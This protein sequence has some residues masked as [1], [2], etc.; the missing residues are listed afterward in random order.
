[1]AAA[2]ARLGV[3]EPVD[4]PHDEAHLAVFED[5]FRVLYGELEMHRRN[6]VIHLAALDLACYDRE[7]ASEERRMEARTRHVERWPEAIENAV[8]SLDMVAPPV[9]GRLLGSVK[10]LAQGLPADGGRAADAARAAHTRLVA[11]LGE[12]AERD[13]GI[14]SAVLGGGPFARLMGSADGLEVD[15]G[16]LAEQA[17]QERDRLLTVLAEATGRIDPER[18]PFD[19]CRELVRDHPKSNGVVDSAG[20][21]A[22]RLIEF[23]R[24]KDLVPY[25]DGRCVVR[26]APESRR[27][28]MAFISL[29]APGEPEGPSVFHV[30]PPDPDWDPKDI[31]E[32]LEIFSAT[33]LPS[34][35]AHEVAPG[36]FSHGRAMLRLGSDIRRILRSESFVEGWAHYAEEMCVE[37]GFLSDD[38]R[39]AIGMC[40]EALVR[41]TRL[42]CALGI[43]S[44]SMTLDEAARR[45]AQDT[46]I[47]GK[48]AEAEAGRALFDP[49]YGRYALGKLAIMDLRERAQREWGSQFS[50]QRFHRALFD[51]GAPPLSLMDAAIARG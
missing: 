7:Y 4:D 42:T 45:F 46:H 51:L 12:V 14:D 36:H 15:L 47:V 3:G 30:S 10:G 49:T 25:H 18:T 16:L 38:P 21:W 37:E 6:P 41:V 22:E 13:E 43:H 35:T 44:G 31:D 39:F 17:R 48:G 9:A 40:L 23:T 34:I 32:W 24:L 19:V 28:G 8:D 26:V 2:V 50:L 11:H 33:T 29:S 27:W 5:Q 1:M 20:Q